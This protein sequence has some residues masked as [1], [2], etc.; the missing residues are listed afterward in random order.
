MSSRGNLRRSFMICLVIGA[1]VAA[2]FGAALIVSA[3]SG[4]HSAGSIL[5][6]GVGLIIFIVSV[7]AGCSAVLS[8]RSSRPND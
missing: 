2:L 1:G 3:V 7:S 5:L 4:E 8:L 6:A